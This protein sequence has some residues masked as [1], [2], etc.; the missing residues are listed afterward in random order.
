M[1]NLLDMKSRQIKESTTSWT[2]KRLLNCFL[3]FHQYQIFTEKKAILLLR[4]TLSG[5]LFGEL[6][7]HRIRPLRRVSWRVL[8]MFYFLEIIK[9]RFAE[10][11]R[12]S[13][14]VALRWHQHHLECHLISYLLF[15]SKFSVENIT[16][17]LNVQ[18]PRQ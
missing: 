4:R 13:I 2:N 10:G 6:L 1:T 11:G 16:F 14:Y 8:Q 17:F 12:S 5:Q 18:R 9:V 7:Y 15:L 3:N